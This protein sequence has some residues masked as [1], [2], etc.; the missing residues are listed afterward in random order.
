MNADEHATTGAAVGIVT[1]PVA[2]LAGA[3]PAV[4]VGSVLAG[5]IWPDVDH[6]GAS[7]ARMWGPVSGV[8]CGA[9]SPVLGGHRG[10]T[11][12][13]L[14]GVLGAAL[15][16]A[17]A[18]VHPVSSAV[19]WAVL[20]G[21]MLAALARALHWPL[22]WPFNLAVSTVAGILAYTGGWAVLPAVPG[23]AVGVVVH[24]IGDRWRTRSW[25]ARTAVAVSYLAVTAVLAWRIYPHIEGITS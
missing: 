6:P 14:F 8:V 7:I 17:A 1:V 2:A 20:V 13:P 22:W 11:H 12:H 25:Q 4:W 21:V 24:L 15:V 5:S 10:V 3:T 9:V 23:L 18:S 16:I 19:A